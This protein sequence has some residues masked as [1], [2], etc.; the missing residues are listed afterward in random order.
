MNRTHSTRDITVST[1]MRNTPPNNSVQ[2]KT[3]LLEDL[4][5]MSNFRLYRSLSQKEVLRRSNKV[6]MKTFRGINQ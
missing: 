3:N 6:K 1:W 5:K 4:P 2:M